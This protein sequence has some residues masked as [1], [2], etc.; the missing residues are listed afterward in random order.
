M[1]KRLLAVFGA[2]CDMKDGI[3]IPGGD[4]EIWPLGPNG[5]R[6][7]V[8]QDSVDDNDPNAVI[9]MGE[10][11]LEAAV[12]IYPHVN[13]D[14][15]AIAYGDSSPSL[16][17]DGHPSENEVMSEYFEERHPKARLEIFDPVEWKSGGSASGTYHE[18][19]NLLRLMQRDAIDEVFIVHRKVHLRAM[20]L[21]TLRLQEPEFQDLAKRIRI[22]SGSVES[23]LTKSDPDKFW[24]RIWNIEDSKAYTR[25]LLREGNWL[26]NF[27]KKGSTQV[28]QKPVEQ[29]ILATK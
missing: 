5:G 15:V 14:S 9:G 16:K 22:Q 11:T 7:I 28:V 8:R 6:S 29:P 24:K 10:L 13:P 21:T 18:V 12:A 25:S 17:L 3:W 26:Y 1:A 2:G 23:I 4:F 20:E 19:A 27:I